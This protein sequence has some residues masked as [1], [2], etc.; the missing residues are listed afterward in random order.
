MSTFWNFRIQH[1]AMAWTQSQFGKNKTEEVLNEFE[2]HLNQI[3]FF[4][5]LM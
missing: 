2:L 3:F 1:A 5:S 4:I